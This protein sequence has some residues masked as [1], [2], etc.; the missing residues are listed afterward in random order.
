MFLLASCDVVKTAEGPPGADA[1]DMGQ[2]RQNVGSAMQSPPGAAQVGSDVVDPLAAPMID[3]DAVRV[4]LLL[5][6]SGRLEALGEAMLNAAQLALFDNAD[7]RFELLPY[8]TKGTPVGAAAAAKIAVRDGASM[9]LGPLLAGSVRAVAPEAFA[10]GIP[11]I[12]FSSN[13]SVAGEGTYIMGFTPSTEIDHIVAHAAQSGIGR[14][15]AIVPNNAYGVIIAETARKAAATHGI[16]VTHLE[17]YDPN[18]QDFNAAVQRTVAA[19]SSHPASAGRSSPAGALILAEGGERLR[20]LAAYLPAHGIDPQEVQLL[21]PG[22]WDDPSLGDEELLVGGRFA[23]PDPRF[24]RRFED[25]Y[26][27][28]FGKPA[29]RLT[30]LAY[31][32]VALAASIARSGEVDPFRPERLTDPQGF[33]GRDGLFRFR[34]NGTPHR[35]LAIQEIRPGGIQVIEE[36]L[37]RFPGS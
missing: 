19:S 5:P 8:D 36:S 13:R 4:A 23:A 2:P 17:L 29:P 11:V 6:L 21:G 33:F 16:T 35:S 7:M 20:S 3:T 25:R 12:A 15:A 34:Q 22:A 14:V 37:G 27:S 24:R 28:T 1:N 32:A 30:T 10:A 26:R 9:V 18:T 31:D